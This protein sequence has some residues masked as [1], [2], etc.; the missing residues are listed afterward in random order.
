RSRAHV[1]GQAGPSVRSS[2]RHIQEWWSSRTRAC[3]QG[4]SA[5]VYNPRFWVPL[6]EVTAKH[7]DEWNRKWL[8]YWRDIARSTD[9]RTTIAGIAPHAGSDFTLRV[10]FPAVKPTI[11]GIALSAC[12]NSLAFDFCAR[13]M[14]GGTH[15]S[16]YIMKQL[17]V[18]SPDM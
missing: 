16:D 6:K 17:P 2:L 3:R 4:R 8:L 1:R 14:L 9:E 11:G 5:R 12:F 13:Q 7:P 15:L 10:G 18:L